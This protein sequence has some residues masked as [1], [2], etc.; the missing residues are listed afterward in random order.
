MT[1][2]KRQHYIAQMHLAHFTDVDG[3]LHY[4]D[5][6]A[7]DEIRAAYPND[8]F[9]KKHLYTVTKADG[10]RDVGLE[11]EFSRIEGAV[12]PLFKRII[13]ASRANTVPSLDD[14][15]RQGL[16]QYFYYQW[17]RVPEFHAR[18][19]SLESFDVMLPT[20]I[21][22]LERARG[23]PF[24]PNERARLTSPEGRKQMFEMARAR[25]IADPGI[26]VLKV[27]DKVGLR[28]GRISAPA[29]LVIGS[30][31]VAVVRHPGTGPY[32]IWLP[33]AYD[34]GLVLTQL[35]GSSEYFVVED[36]GVAARINAAMFA[37]SFLIAGRSRAVV[38][39][40]V[41]SA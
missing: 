12:S 18:I 38:E 32:E 39:Q 37:Q 26:E 17:K 28:F 15:E 11:K 24:D 1:D 10:S 41:T 8:V 16:Q 22:E 29:E 33:I 4:H 9:F 20:F 36:P 27:I 7:G 25:A 6:R 30:Q 19:S 31:P 35:R 21:T 2:P 14:E 3:R 23:E 34:T 40:L 5:K 13:E